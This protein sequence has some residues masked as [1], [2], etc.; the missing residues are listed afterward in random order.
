[1]LDSSVVVDTNFSDKVDSVTDFDIRDGVPGLDLDMASGDSVWTPLRICRPQ[2]MSSA[3][4][5]Q[6]CV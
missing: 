1:M 3:N 5:Q 4:G 6:D 2:Q